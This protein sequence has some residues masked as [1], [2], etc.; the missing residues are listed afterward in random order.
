MPGDRILGPPESACYTPQYCL[1]QN[2]SS[3]VPTRTSGTPFLSPTCSVV[4][5][6]FPWNG[7]MLWPYSWER[8]CQGWLGVSGCIHTQEDCLALGLPGWLVCGS[9]GTSTHLCYGKP[10]LVPRIPVL[11]F[12]CLW[13]LTFFH[14]GLTLTNNC[15][16][17]GVGRGCLTLQLD[18]ALCFLHSLA[19]AELPRR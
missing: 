11:P 15:A 9:Q 5:G 14:E 8:K 12:I 2:A 3:C 4:Q 13:E 6:A 16:C 17:L 18:L 1:H 7:Y 10:F 19:G